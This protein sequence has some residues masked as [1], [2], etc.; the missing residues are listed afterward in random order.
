[1]FQRRRKNELSLA[2]QFSKITP[3]LILEEKVNTRFLDTYPFLL[4]SLSLYLL[5]L[6]R[7]NE[8]NQLPIYDYHKCL[9]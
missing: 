7:L 8:Y 6:Q 9:F 5:L 2:K 1:M 4:V 3:I